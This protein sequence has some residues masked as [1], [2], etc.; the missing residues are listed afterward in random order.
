MAIA[1]ELRGRTAADWASK[2]ADSSRDLAANLVNPR[3]FVGRLAWIVF[4]TGLT[5]EALLATRL[6]AQLTHQSI[7]SG[8]L[9]MVFDVT[10]FLISPFADMEPSQPIKST[11]VLEF[12]TLVALNAYL[13]ATLAGLLA[14][15][16]L[17]KLVRLVLWASAA[18]AR[19]SD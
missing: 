6:W 12:A 4:F 3:Y 16:I 19:A 7:T 14:L 13:A 11:G 1:I 8:A 15:F 18:A 5:V 10:G 9:A 17:P 2:F